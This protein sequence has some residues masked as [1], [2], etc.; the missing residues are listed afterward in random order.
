M[1]VTDI[2]GEGEQETPSGTM[3]TCYVELPCNAFASDIACS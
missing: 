3:L 1:A 2:T